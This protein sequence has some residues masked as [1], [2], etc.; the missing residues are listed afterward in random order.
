MQ[1]LL[2]PVLLVVAAVGLLILELVTFTGGLAFAAALAYI[3]AVAVAYYEAGPTV[4]T[5]FLLA[6]MFGGGLLTIGIVKWAP[7]SVLG[8]ALFN[9]PPDNAEQE[10]ALQELRATIGQVGEATCDMLPGGV[11]QIGKRRFEALSETGAVDKGALV[12]VTAVRGLRLVVREYRPRE[13]EATQAHASTDP[14]S[15]PTTWE[16][17]IPDPFE[18]PLT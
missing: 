18:D 2:I 5:I 6:T 17:Q 4:G 10:A 3:V 15:T 11:V 16:P 12:Q 9:P 13:L 14:G 7:R 1:E 8:S